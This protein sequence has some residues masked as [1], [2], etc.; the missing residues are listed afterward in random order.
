MK[1]IMLSILVVLLG[2]T[3]LQAGTIKGVVEDAD[4]EEPLIGANI[5]LKGTGMGA[6]T[7]MDGFFLIRNV[8]EGDYSLEASYVGFNEFRETISVGAGD[9]DMEISLK[10]MVYS[11]SEITILADRAKPR[12]TPVAYS[13]VEK[14]EIQARLGSRDIPLVLNTTPSVYA[15]YNGG[16]AGDSRISIRGFNQRNVAVMIN[17]I[18]VNDMENGWVYWSN[19]DGLG[20]ATNS[21]QVQR[22]LSAVNLATPSIG[23]SMNIITD[24]N[25]QNFGLLFKQEIGNDGF[26]KSTISGNSG[27]INGKYAINASVVRKIGDGLVDKTWTDAWAYYVGASW[28]V[29]KNHRLEAYFM[30][31]PQRHGQNYYKQNIGAYSHEFAKKLDDY[32]PAALEE[33]PESKSGVN[34]NQ[35]WNKVSSTYTGEQYWDGQR[36]DRY[37]SGIINE[38]ENYYHKPLGNVNWY[39]NLTEKLNLYTTVYYSGGMGGGSGT[40]GSLRWDYDSEPTRIADWDATIARNAAADTSLGILRNSVNNQWTVGAISKATYNFTEKVTGTFGVDWRTAEIEHFREVRDLLGGKYYYDDTND[41]DMG[42]QR[43]KFLGDR[44]DYNNTNTV[45]WFGFY[46][47]GEYKTGMLTAYGM[48]GYS[49]IKYTYTDHFQHEANGDEFKLESDWINGVQVKGGANYKLTPELD[50][51]GNVGLVSKVPIFDEVI[52]DVDGTLA[53]DPKNEKFTNLEAGANYR[54]FAGRL[55]LKGNIYYTIWNDKTLTRNIRKADNSEA[56]IFIS[57]LDSRHAGV[58]F[59]GAYQPNRLVRLDAAASFGNWVYTN[60][61]SGVYKDYDNPTNPDI[62]YT[63]YLKD[64]KIGDAPQMQFAVGGTVFP[65]RG[66]QAQLL[67]RYYANHYADWDSE[68]RQDPDDRAQSWKVPNYGVMDL[69]ALYDLPIN[70]KG[71]RFQV[72]FHVFNVLDTE[73][74]TDAIDNSAYNSFTD[75]NGD[76][77]NPHKADAAE[78]YFGLL[79]TFN[80]G[81]QVSF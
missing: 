65:I 63:Y 50:I 15:T 39:A 13:N 79:R 67:Y 78:V 25:A 71:V 38:R 37:D 19:W 5:I 61:V 30:G 72:F 58:E 18:P 32:D 6:T 14:K 36:R 9:V 35:T 2:L 59:E 76:I 66:L 62:D 48:A 45:D 34:Y 7:D 24:P 68:S 53:D 40:L 17:G 21:L 4:T 69:H 49:M 1:Q 23:G 43:L 80:S 31:A 81:I 11:G 10:Q 77:V 73:F 75:D 12:E 28:N 44:I 16:A 33:F 70:L 20:D 55:V 64:L 47:Q 74:I 51:F 57:G 56:L 54:A 52:S 60:D 42:T 41:L 46:G 27:L 22:G 26:L 3:I 29:N 8:P